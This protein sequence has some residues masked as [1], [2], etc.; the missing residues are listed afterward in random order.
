M[1][2]GALQRT[3]RD[4][5]R[6]I[7]DATSVFRPDEVSMALALFDDAPSSNYEFLGGFED[8]NL[9]AVA[10]MRDY[11]APCDDRVISRSPS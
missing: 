1:R 9:V 7:L 5:V 11:Y 3:H 4:R 2:L 8:D 6:E 10:R